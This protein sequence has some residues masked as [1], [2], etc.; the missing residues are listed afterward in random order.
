VEIQTTLRG[1]YYED[2]YNENTVGD[3]VEDDIINSAEAG[4][5][6]GYLNA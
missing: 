4:F 1:L 3:Y 6:I 2:I 5:M